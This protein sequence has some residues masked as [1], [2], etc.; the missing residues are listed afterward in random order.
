MASREKLLFALAG[1]GLAAAVA[2]HLLLGAVPKLGTGIGLA[3]AYFHTIPIC[4][5]PSNVAETFDS[6]MRRVNTRMHA[7]MNTVRSG[8]ADHDFAA[9]MIAH[10]QG[11]IEMARVQLKYG[12]DEQLRRLAQ[13]II[14]E[15]G[16]EIA[17]MRIL[18]GNA[19]AT[20]GKDAADH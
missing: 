20:S 1:F 9:M 8:N 2:W 19:R 18:L 17:Y 16:Q 10:H 12:R 11:A 5:D 3:H 4:G 13:S 6:E 7:G 14:V 15:Q